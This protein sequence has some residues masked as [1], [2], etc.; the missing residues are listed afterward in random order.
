MRNPFRVVISALAI[1]T[2]AAHDVQNTCTELSFRG[3]VHDGLWRQRGDV[4]S[5]VGE[6]VFNALPRNVPAPQHRPMCS[7]AAALRDRLE[8]QLLHTSPQHLPRHDGHG[9]CDQTVGSKV[10]CLDQ[11]QE[12]LHFGIPGGRMRDKDLLLQGSLDSS[13]GSPR[14]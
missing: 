5:L 7:H 3:L 11:A 2:T 9:H 13:R 10:S 4:Q 6:R 14:R 1:Y 8:A 12:A